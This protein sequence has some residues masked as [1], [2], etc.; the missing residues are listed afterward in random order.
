MFRILIFLLFCSSQ[1]FAHTAVNEACFSGCT[2]TSNTHLVCPAS[3][4]AAAGWN[5]FGMAG[6][7]NFFD[8]LHQDTCHYYNG[9]AWVSCA[10]KRYSGSTW[11]DTDAQVYTSHLLE[12]IYMLFL[13]V[14]PARPAYKNANFDQAAAMADVDTTTVVSCLDTEV[15]R[16]YENFTQGAV[17][18]YPVVLAC[19]T[20][21]TWTGNR[22]FFLHPDNAKAALAT[23]ML[24]T[25]S[26][27]LTLEVELTAFTADSFIT[28]IM[29]GM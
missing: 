15:V 12:P 2:Y 25:N 18:A 27:T 22:I 17:N 4:C 29:L 21:S 13:D 19:N 3:D 10:K 1:A 16:L 20:A 7:D 6:T 26:P 24:K 5:Q 11:V 23:M 28:S 9:T 14:L 8:R